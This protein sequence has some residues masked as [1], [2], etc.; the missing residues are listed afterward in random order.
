MLLAMITRDQLRQMHAFVH[1]VFWPVL[2][3]YIARLWAT[4]CRA[5]A[6]GRPAV[7]YYVSPNGMIRIGYMADSA[8]ERAAREPLGP[9]FDYTPWMRL[10]PADFGAGFGP[11]HHRTAIGLFLD[12]CRTVSGCLPDPVFAPP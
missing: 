6:E 5:G 11:D 3:I 7:L 4:L 8:G 12:C 2:W 10:A 1:P 9:D